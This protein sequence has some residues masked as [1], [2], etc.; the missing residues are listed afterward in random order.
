MGLALKAGAHME[1]DRQYFID[2]GR[3]AVI[4]AFRHI[5]QRAESP[6]AYFDGAHRPDTPRRT[7]TRPRRFVM[8]AV[9]T[10]PSGTSRPNLV[11]KQTLDGAVHRAIAE[12]EPLEFLWVQYRYRPDGLARVQHGDNFLRRYFE[13]YQSSHLVNCKTGTRRMVRYLISVAMHN[14]TNPHQRAAQPDG[15]D[16]SPRNWNKTYRPH[17]HRICAELTKLDS[18]ALYSLGLLVDKGE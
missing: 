9:A 5:R 11:D 4:K 10:R 16:T 2:V 6:V 3:R 18:D 15:Y 17:W 7:P 8:H 14:E 1:A 13:R 12:L